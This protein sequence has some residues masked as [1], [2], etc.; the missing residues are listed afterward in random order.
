MG[1]TLR[2]KTQILV[3]FSKTPKK[4]LGF[5]D[6]IH[7]V[8]VGFYCFTVYYTW[9]LLVL[10]YIIRGFYWSYCILY[11]GFIDFTVYCARVLYN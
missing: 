6:N 1:F 5:F 3:S 7:Y 10:M 8:V 9:V 4:P 2:F 11:V